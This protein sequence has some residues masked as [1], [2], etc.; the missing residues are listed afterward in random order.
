MLQ[1]D[2]PDLIVP[3]AVDADG[4]AHPG[5]QIIKVGEAA[6]LLRFP[7]L[8]MRIDPAC[9]DDAAGVL[10]GRTGRSLEVP[11]VFPERVFQRSVPRMRPRDLGDHSTPRSMVKRLDKGRQIGDVVEHVTADNDIRRSG[12]RSRLRPGAY[13]REIRGT[14]LEHGRLAVHG[15]DPISGWPQRQ[16][17]GAA[18]GAHIEHLAAGRQCLEGAMVRRGQPRMPGF[19]E[20]YGKR[21]G[22]LWRLG[23]DVLRDRPGG[24]PFL[25]AAG[26]GR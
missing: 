3:R 23:K 14:V 10:P 24:E 25:P 8:D 6:S 12:F 5:D 16:R 17:H 20:R 22:I 1:H 13:H 11:E 18:A 21:P 7:E 15:N 19:K 2:G 9:T 26:R 4:S